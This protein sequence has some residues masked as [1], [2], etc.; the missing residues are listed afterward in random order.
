MIRVKLFVLLIAVG[1]IAPV[2]SSR[3]CA[4]DDPN[5]GARFE[6]AARPVH[7]DAG[8]CSGICDIASHTVLKICIEASGQ[9]DFCEVLQNCSLPSTCT[10]AWSTWSDLS[11]RSATCNGEIKKQQRRCFKRMGVSTV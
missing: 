9:L 7:S 1:L 4:C 6:G 10:G 3:H 5:S 11:S 8:R 2:S